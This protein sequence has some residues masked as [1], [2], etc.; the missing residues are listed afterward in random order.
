[1]KVI[2]HMWDIYKQGWFE[3]EWILTDE[4]FQPLYGEIASWGLWLE[5]MAEDEHMGEAE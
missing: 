1:M 4:Q 2:K 5:Y 3:V